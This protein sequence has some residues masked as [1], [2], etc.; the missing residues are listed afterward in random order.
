MSRGV[1]IG[2]S[3]DAEKVEAIYSDGLN[4]LRPLLGKPKIERASDV[5]YDEDREIWVAKR[6]GTDEVL[7]EST[8]RDE[9]IKQEVRILG[10]ELVKKL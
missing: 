9:C 7:C 8:S 1:C 4:G 3:G 6:K 2:I 5:T 10:S